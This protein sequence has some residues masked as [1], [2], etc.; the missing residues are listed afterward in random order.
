MRRD[1]PEPKQS[2]PKQSK[3][4][5]SKKKQSKPKPFKP[6]QP[7]RE[8][9][10]PESRYEGKKEDY[11]TDF[12]GDE[13]DAPPNHYRTLDIDP[14]STHEEVL[15]AA[16]KKRIETHPDKFIKDGLP[17][18]GLTKVIETSKNVGWAADILCDPKKRQKYDIEL[19]VWRATH[20]E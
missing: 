8:Q 18:E 14:S 7:E 4:R 20:F 17:S 9:Y 11:S 19:R 5:Q 3:T 12:G 13:E 2:K 6:K 16:R 1:Q 15:R 10:K